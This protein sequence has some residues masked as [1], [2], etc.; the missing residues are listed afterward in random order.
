MKLKLNALLE[1]LSNGMMK[2]RAMV[3]ICSTALQ[4]KNPDCFVIILCGWSSGLAVTK[5]HQKQTVLIY[6]Y[7]GLKLRDR[8]SI[9]NKF[10]ITAE[11]LSQ[12]A[13]V[14]RISKPKTF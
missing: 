5:T 1:R 14:A 3:K 13:V 10:D 11:Q 4:G 7:V 6:A 8:V 9:F 2:L 12:L